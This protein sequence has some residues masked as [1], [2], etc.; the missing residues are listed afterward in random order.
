MKKLIAFSLIISNLVALEFGQIGNT[1]ASV[2]GAGVAYKKNAWAV[3]YNPALLGAN[4]QASIAYSFGVG[5]ADSNVLELASIDVNALKNI[6]DEMNGLTQ[7]TTTQTGGGDNQPVTFSLSRNGIATQA[8]GWN[9]DDLGL[10][11]EV[12]GN[13]TATNGTAGTNESDL[14]KYLCTTMNGNGTTVGGNNC[15]SKGLDK[16]AEDLRGNTNALATI[17]GE[18]QQAIEKT[19]ANGSDKTALDI[20]GSIVE[21]IDPKNIAGLVESVEGGNVNLKT[22]LDKIGGSVKISKG[23]SPALDSLFTIVNTI[24]KNSLNI[25]SNNGIAWHIKG[26]K[27]RGAIGM[28]ILANVYGFAG[29]ELDSTHKKII[30]ENGSDY[31]EV[32]VSG[33]KI[34]LGTADSNAYNN[35]SILAPNANHKLH[36]NSIAITEIP[37]A[38][39]HT[40]PLHLGDLHLGATLKYIFAASVNNSQ[41]FDFDN[42]KINFGNVG[43][44]LRYTH[45]FGVDLGA[46]YTI[47]WLST[48]IVVKNLNAPTIRTADGKYHIL[49]QARA[50]VSAEIWKLTFLADIDL[51]PNDTLEPGK[52]NQMVG[53]G[54]ILD[55]RWV[56]FRFGVMSDMHKNPYGPIFTA[57]LNIAHFLDFT[58]QTNTNLI[59]IKSAN[60]G[61]D[62][63]PNYFKVSFGGRFQW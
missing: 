60:V 30:I 38:Y 23:T 49:P 8:N 24:N 7:K 59:D 15:E 52:K 32:G 54:V 22:M 56:D 1:P 17:K 26:N 61:V 63:I 45:T 14:K 58:V 4:R 43:D 5:Y 31:F 44:N 48:G 57:G 2:G 10:L 50:G 35:S 41:K 39:G 21:N 40:I 13:L 28:G 62:R 9:F 29:V 12:L 53:G 11:G 37:I 34:T 19:P 51:T 42:F 33:D 3:Y 55:L 16:I 6:Q 27:D 36:A 18:L 20:L 25:S 46:L 47:K